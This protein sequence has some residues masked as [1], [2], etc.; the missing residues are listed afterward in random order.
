MR[1]AAVAVMAL[2]GANACSQNAATSTATAGAGADAKATFASQIDAAVADATPKVETT[3]PIVDAGK[4]DAAAANDVGAEVAAAAETTVEAVSGGCASDTDCKDPTLPRC[5][6]TS[7]ACV[8][9]LP[10][11]DNCATGS[12]CSNNSAAWSCGSGCKTDVECQDGAGGSA[13]SLCCDHQCVDTATDNA[14]CGGCDGICDGA[15]TCCKGLCKNYSAD[16][17]NCG[18]CGVPCKIAN[19]TPSCKGGKCAAASCKLGFANCNGLLD[20]GCET[21]TQTSPD[22][23]GKCFDA[24]QPKNATGKCAAGKCQVDQCLAGFVDCNASATDGCEADLANDPKYCGNCQTDCGPGKLCTLGKCH[25][26]CEAFFSVA[27]GSNAAPAIGPD[28][29]VY[30][31]GTDG[32]L[33]AFAANTG[34]TKWTSS[35]SI[36][37]SHTNYYAIGGVAIGGSQFYVGGPDGNLY[38]FDAKGVLLW[39]TMVGGDLTYATPAVGGALLNGAIVAVGKGTQMAAVTPAGA[40]VWKFTLGGAMMSSSPAIGT[41]GTTYLA[42][43]DDGMLYA[44]KADGTLNWKKDNG[45]GAVTSPAIGADGRIYTGNHGPSDGFFRAF[46]PDG[47]V[48]WKTQVG[49]FHGGAAIAGDGTVYAGNDFTLVAL[50]AAG[51]IKWQASTGGGAEP[52]VC[53]G[54]MVGDDGNVYVPVCGNSTIAV[55]EPLKGK[56]LCTLSLNGGWGSAPTLGQNGLMYVGTTTGQLIAYAGTSHRLDQTSPW[57]KHHRDIGNTGKM[58]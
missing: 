25:L 24:C 22:S 34:A 31:V 29:T 3:T 45:G 44:I 27:G 11:D 54:N 23:C 41:D 51:S 7:Q 28:G 53:G 20:D 14:H 52:W 39:K 47:T 1:V 57:P 2:C 8:P 36:G 18:G 30:E 33:R 19:A 13:G 32:F 46:N 5:D 12:F 49:N 48:A 15:V 38:A 35:A 40:V 6:T 26:P 50:N 9:C 4:P 43:W 10:A 56:V 37:A 21:N 17:D 55:M 42:T 58:P 16:P